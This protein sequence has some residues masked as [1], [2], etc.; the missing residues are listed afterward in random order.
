MIK[1]IIEDLNENYENILKQICEDDFVDLTFDTEDVSICL[2]E[3]DISVE[4]IPDDI[5]SDD[6]EDTEDKKTNIWG[7]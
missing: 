2:N 1:L 4:I 3:Q 7:F 5:V 6:P